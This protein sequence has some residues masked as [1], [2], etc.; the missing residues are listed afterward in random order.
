MK[1]HLLGR[2]ASAA[3]ALGAGT[4]GAAVV[5]DFEGG[6]VGGWRNTDSTLTMSVV[7]GGSQGSNYALRVDRTTGGWNQAMNIPLSAEQWADVAAGSTVS[8]DVK[9]Q[10]GTDVP[11]WWLQLFPTVN[12]QNGGWVNASK[13]D[14]TLDGQWHTYTATY[15]PQP[16]APGQWS[17]LFLI[18][19]GG[20]GA[21][22]SGTNMT[23]Y[24][25]NVSVGPTAPVPEPA[26]LALV[27][28]AGLGLMRR[29]R[30]A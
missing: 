29:R 17:E 13:T 7:P 16:S 22:P 11:G 19:Q 18:N 3:L 10:G 5:S 25:D 6:T 20:A 30:R 8:I 4:A 14:V 28:V 26:S 15:T 27:G 21:N 1:R 9:A 23:F 12:S 24:I 2:A